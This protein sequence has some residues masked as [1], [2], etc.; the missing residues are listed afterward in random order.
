[1]KVLLL[2]PSC[3]MYAEI[4]LRLE[5]L[6]LELVAAS[7]RRAGH[8]VRIV[9]LQV[10]R[11][12]DYFRE[13]E[14]WRPDAVGFCLN[15]LA[16]VPEVLDLAIHTRRV[17]PDGFLF[18]GGHSASFV[19]P[20]I[21][22]HAGAALD[23]IV[24]GEGE[25]IVPRLL[26]ASRDDRDRLH[27]LPGIV[28][29]HGQGP[30]PSLIDNLDALE[31]AR[32]LLRQRKRYFIG[33]LDPCGSVE[34]SRGCP[35]D[36]TF[37]S[38]WTFYGRSYRK[39]GA[40]A[41]AE[42]LARMPERGVFIVDDVAFLDADH[43][44]AIADEI[45]RRKIR[46]EYYLETRSDLLLRHREVFRRWQKLGL[47]YMF[48]GLEALDDEGL[49]R[50]RKRTTVDRGMEALA[51][52]RSLGIAAA[53]NIIAQPQWDERQFEA[54]R[55]WAISVPEI[56]HLTVATPYPGTETW[57]GE[58]HQ[59]TT[60]DYRLFDIQHA[61]LPTRLP[62]EKFYRELVRTQQVL[63]RKHLGLAA[64]CH[65]LFRTIRLLARGQ[66]NFFRMLWKFNSVYNPARQLADHRRQVRYEM[67]LPEASAGPVDRRSLYVHRPAATGQEGNGN[68][69]N[70]VIGCRRRTAFADYAFASTSIGDWSRLL[71]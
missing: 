40:E 32:D 66:S 36:C 42:N 69:K 58:A 57:L 46:K 28:T 41:A 21:L 47:R 18:A 53:V 4:Y 44:H 51:V 17:L 52:A 33:P 68:R 20:E 45:D 50:F 60:R 10:Q 59:L 61:V 22:A 71:R 5:P 24:C 6:G 8:E 63:N 54:V 16:N 39:V 13:L 1:M 2:H 55:Q 70:A 38:A 67:A 29:K 35:W 62:L 26:E 23:C 31:P 43:A 11:P 64:Q 65:A 3:L 9:D 49:E 19:A 34:F 25:A 14:D 7:A 15:Y 27:A 12:A 48:L 56:V 37:C 30:P